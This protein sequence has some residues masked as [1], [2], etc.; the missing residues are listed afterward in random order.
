MTSETLPAPATE[1]ASAPPANGKPTG[2]APAQRA[3][4]L[5]TPEVWKP[6]FTELTT[7]YRHLPELLADGEA[8]RY[9][10][11]KGD[12]V[13]HAWDTPRDAGLYGHER[14][15]DEIFMIHKVD[16][17]EVERLAPYFPAEEDV[18]C[19]H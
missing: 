1:S 14:F 11:I 8:G 18:A 16:P 17:R 12:E 6:L 2:P 5:P 7:Y 10:V 3:E 4:P 13:C 15:G 19:Q 9:V